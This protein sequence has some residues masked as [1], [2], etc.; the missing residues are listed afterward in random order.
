[1]TSEMKA[2]PV[3]VNACT[4]KPGN[5]STYGGSNP[6]LAIFTYMG[7]VNISDPEAIRNLRDACDYALRGWYGGAD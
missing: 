1:M 5:D 6:H 4:A 7:A 3:G 2:F